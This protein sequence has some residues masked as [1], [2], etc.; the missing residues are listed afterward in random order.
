MSDYEFVKTA[1]TMLAEA[2][3]VNKFTETVWLCVDRHDWDKFQA[4]LHGEKE[5][6][7]E[8]V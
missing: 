4:A 3:V 7:T 6:E 2:E 5:N 1:T 8:N